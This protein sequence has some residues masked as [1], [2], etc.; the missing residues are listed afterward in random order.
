MLRSLG[1]TAT[2]PQSY[3]FTGQVVRPLDLKRH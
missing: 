3:V 1:S 2:Q